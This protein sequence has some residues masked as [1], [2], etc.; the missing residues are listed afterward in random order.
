MKNF[1]IY[2]IMSVGLVLIYFY[3]IFPIRNYL[4]EQVGMKA[5]HIV[6]GCI[7]KE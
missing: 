1:L 5:S 7:I 4:C 2:F 3:I 6:K